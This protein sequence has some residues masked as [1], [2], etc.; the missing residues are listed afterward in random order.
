MQIW[1]LND[2]KNFQ[3]LV[4][5]KFPSLSRI[6]YSSY[7]P[8]SRIIGIVGG[9]PKGLYGLD[10]AVN[11]IKNSG[12]D[13]PTEIHW[14]NNSNRFAT[15]DNYRM[16]QPEYLL[17]NFPIEKI[18]M[19][20][21][22]NRSN[23]FAGLAFNGSMDQWLKMFV[24]GSAKI[25]VGDFAS[26]ALVGAY[27]T[28]GAVQILESLPPNLEVKCIEGNVED[29]IPDVEA[30]NY[31][32][33][34]TG[35]NI[36]PLLKYERILLAT[37][38]TYTFNDRL[39]DEVDHFSK[40]SGS[41]SYVGH[42]YPVDEKLKAIKSS[43]KVCIKGLGLTFVDTVL[44]LTEGRG[45]TFINSEKSICYSPSGNEPISIYAYS[46]SGAPMLPRVPLKNGKEPR[47]SYISWDWVNVLVNLKGRG[48]IDFEADVLPVLVKEYQILHQE[49][50]ME[51]NA[52]LLKCREPAYANRG[53][54]LECN[55]PVY[56]S[57]VTRFS[58]QD[59]LD[60]FAELSSDLNETEY[61]TLVVNYLQEAVE[62]A[63]NYPEV[64]PILA[65]SSV[66]RNAL[67]YIGSLYAFGGFTGA[68]QELFEKQYLG[69]FNRI[70]FGPPLVNVQK[71]LALIKAGNLFFR[72]GKN[73]SVI[74]NTFT[75][76][77]KVYSQKTYPCQDVNYLLDARIAKPTLFKGCPKLYQNLMK[78]GLAIP[79]KNGNHMPGCL[80]IDRNG[81]LIGAKEET[82]VGITLYGTP[83][84]GVT[85]DNDSLSRERNDFASNWAGRWINSIKKK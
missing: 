58:I 1:K 21:I 13:I 57:Q 11:S 35:L 85:L 31:C 43:D 34:L 32:L 67:P 42:V 7:K 54:E 2:L 77:F 68:S 9:G 29:I 18:N 25:A 52:Y 10:A 14:F 20:D 70:S 53:K 56:S 78:R 26:R 23:S 69:K 81:N 41:A 51:R 39:G 17:I 6:Q 84:E 62:E 3:E 33:E 72:P 37:G 27:L 65:L 66:W 46:K 45:G 50:L 64:S 47:L 79:F 40:Q 22:S 76:N 73:T 55:L 19:W 49:K 63:V 28:A 75:G 44:A 8:N 48:N 83:T 5:F 61:H 15:G 36:N 12:V 4:D 82:I 16:D 38:H 60:P 30:E 74:P 71:I 24:F 80:A 59:I